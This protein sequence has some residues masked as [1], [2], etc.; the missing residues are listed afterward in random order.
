MRTVWTIAALVIAGAIV[1]I[2]F[3]G[4][5]NRTPQPPSQ[6]PAQSAPVLP[7]VTPTARP[8]EATITPAVPVELAVLPPLRAMGA[9]KQSE[10]TSVIGSLDP[11]SGHK[12]RVK[13]TGFGAGV[14]EVQLTD[15]FQTVTRQEHYT[16]LSKVRDPA[17]FSLYP[18]A[19][20]SVT[21]NGQTVSLQDQVWHTD[22]SIPGAYSIDIVDESN[23]PVLTLKRRYALGAGDLGYDIRLEQSLINRSKQVLRVSLEQNGQPDPT[24]DEV[25]YMGDRRQIIAGYTYLRGSLNYPNTLFHDHARL[26]ADVTERGRTLWPDPEA[27]PNSR[28]LWIAGVNRYFALATHLPVDP[29]VPG[30]ARSL[31]STFPGLGTQIVGFH[32]PTKT[33]ERT[34]LITHRSAD[35]DLA[36]GTA[37]G[38]ATDSEK[39]LDLSL[40]AGPRKNELFAQEP[41]SRLHFSELVV[42]NLGGPC[43][44]CTFQWLAHALLWFLKLIE[45]A[46]VS[47]AGVG[48]GLHDWGL[49]IIVLVLI[50]R[51]LL[52]PITKRAQI[53]MMKMGKQM[54]ALQP[55]MEKLKKKYEGDQ[56]KIN[57]ETMKLY[58]EKGVNPANMLGCL[59]M[60]LQMPIWF[61]LYAMLYFA[62]EL[63]HQPAFYGV[64]Q[65]VSGGSWPFLADL[66]AQDRFIP[67]PGGGFTIPW[68][69]WT[70][71]ALNILPILMAVVF[72]FQ[73]KLTTPPPANEQAAQQQAMMKWMVLLF[74][75]FLYKAPSGLT[76]Y[77]MASTFAGIVDSWIVK[78]H[79]KREEEA[80]TL[81][82]NKPHK[83][84][85]LMD[86]MTRLLEEKQKQLQQSQQSPQSRPRRERH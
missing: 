18:F 69:N 11:A 65:A 61:A 41:Y 77:I 32:G 67:I 59:P 14:V 40:F 27:Q 28:L 5:G 85:G 60:F 76:L 43:A 71:D 84:G 42:Y 29:A 38:S 70:V 73:Q 33:D 45:G 47:I 2:V 17:G 56:Q 68:L 4:A 79:I 1:A 49:A 26:I 80:G 62:I 81:L 64:F 66:S 75:I 55:E 21:I 36:P 48:I 52:H 25:S 57:Q 74:P 12:L 10:R 15:Y 51:G 54:A 3:M 7:A 20:R 13:L 22:P 34:I 39:A 30:A 44:F 58:R 8:A 19:A 23:A 9:A 31:D 82:Q 37:P 24:M 78:R 53:N 35:F 83:P 16:I 63:R 86:R 46:V 50:V 6:P 72:Y